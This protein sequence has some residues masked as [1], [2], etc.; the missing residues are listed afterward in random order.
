MVYSEN[1]PHADS[2]TPD[3]CQ[4]STKGEQYSPTHPMGSV[5][6]SGYPEVCQRARLWRQL[7]QKHE[8]LQKEQQQILEERKK[9][10]IKRQQ[11]ITEARKTL[12]EDADFDEHMHELN[13]VD[14]RLQRRLTTLEQEI[15]TYVRLDWEE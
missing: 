8:H 12:R 15:D 6:Y 7:Q 1:F 14:E 5:Q 4:C 11:F 3:R 2:K 10:F 13:Q 9:E